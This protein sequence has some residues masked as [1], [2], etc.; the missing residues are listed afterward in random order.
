MTMKRIRQSIFCLMILSLSVCLGTFALHAQTSTQGSI[1]GTVLDPSGAVVS[2]AAVTIHN[3][4]TNAEIKLISDNSGFFKAALLEPGTYRVTFAAPGFSTYRAENVIVSVGQVSSVLPHLTVGASSSSVEVIETAPV[5]NLESPDFSATMNMTALQSIPINNRRWSSLA[6]TTPGVVSDGNGFGLVA[7]RGISPILNNVEIDGADDNQ[8]YY[9]EERGRTREAYSTSAS[10]VREFAVNTGVYSAEYGRA[11]GGVITSVT[12]SGSNQ[13]HGQAYFWDRESKWAAYSNY[14]KLT[15]YNSASNSYVSAPIK[16]ED[17]RKIYGFTAGGAIIKDKLFWIYTYD[18]HSR[19]FPVVGVPNSPAT[20]YTLPA[21]AVPTGATCDLGPAS[22]TLGKMT[23][24][25]TTTATQDGYACTLAARQGITYAAAAAY[26][27]TAITGLTGDIGP[28]ARSGYQE[29]NTPKLDWQINSKEHLSVLY[30]RLNWDS[31]GGVQT[32][33]TDIYAQDT[34][35]NDYVHLNYGVAKLTSLITSNI[36]NELLYQYGRELNDESQQP[37]TS[38]TTNYLTAGG[39]VPEVA[40]ATSTSGFFM[41]SPYYSYRKALPDERKWQIGDVL[42]WNKGNHSL[43]FGVDAVHNDDLMN[44]TYESNGYISYTYLGNYMNDVLN[45][46]NGVTPSSTSKVGCDVGASATYTPA[47][48]TKAAIIPTGTYP[49]YSSLVQGFGNPVFEIATMDTAFFAQDNWKISPRLTLELGLRWDYEALPAPVDNLTTVNATSG[50][51]FYAYPGLTNNPS[52]K[53]NFGPR[54]GFSYDLT[55]GGKT[56]LR[57][58][59][60]I[61]YGRITNGNL[62]NLR[63]NTGSANGQFTST[64][65]NTT[66]VGPQFPYIESATGVGAKPSSYFLAPNL[67]NPTVQEY[68]LMV[69]HSLGKGTYVQAS[70]LG[71][72]GRELPNYLNVNLNPTTTNVTIAVSDASGKGPLPS[73]STYVVPTY[74]SYGNTALFGP[75]AANFQGITEEIGNI[76]SNYNAAVIEV[77]NRSLHSIQFDANYTWSHAL[78]FAQNANTTGATNNWYDP[79]HN[80]RINYGDS[81]YNVPN[82]FVAYVLYSFP[83]LPTTNWVKYLTN[84]WSLNDSFQMQNGLP[85]TISVSSYTSASIGSYWNGASGSTMI[86][87]I[88]VNTMRYPRRMVDD[89]RFQKEIAFGK[90]RN[91]QLMCN[92]FNIANHQNVTSINNTAYVLSGSTAT[93]Q[94]ATYGAVTNTNSQGFLYTPREIEFTARINF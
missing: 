27:A 8:A 42:Y 21:T 20:F 51:Y 34:Q 81:A 33:S 48:G 3:M 91:L 74:T 44:N 1:A 40:L 7:V 63:L 5:L 65:K 53:M 9:A 11:A 62:L 64:Y 12:Q 43:K 45:F 72:L 50:Q 6:M 19:I 59:Y 16:P 2:G 68:D 80:P 41:G 32:A 79:Y 71:A 83:N 76:N 10:A 82:R 77:L 36:G 55:G 26:W 31:P 70:Y 75:N 60:G 18:Q 37:Y 49:C 61:Y 93:F 66:V 69:Q 14:A 67:R 29:I 24:D 46:K 73:G 58:G 54:I 56:V 38:Y 94:S 25:T 17:L 30:H 47:S 92:M 57:G 86:P 35:G 87:S 23:G 78:D 13:L 28:V 22:A 39:N 4:G 89:V 15:T 88:G 52:D 85:Y 84:D 90:G